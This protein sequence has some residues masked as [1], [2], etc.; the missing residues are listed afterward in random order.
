MNTENIV[1][2]NLVFQVESGSYS[3]GTNVEGSDRDMIGAF[4]PPPSNMIG[5]ST[6]EH[7]RDKETDENY[8]SMTDMVKHLRAGSSYWVEPLFVEPA[9]I[10][11]MSRHWSVLQVNREMFLTRALI[12]KTLGFIRGQVMRHEKQKT[13]S[14]SDDPAA[15]AAL[16]RKQIMH[17]VR[18]SYMI[19]DL[20]DE[21][22]FR[23]RRKE[24]PYL[25]DIRNGVVDIND[26]ANEANALH[27]GLSQQFDT[28]TL[29]FP[30]EANTD[31]L[32]E[33]TV[34]AVL[35]YWREKQ[36]I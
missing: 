29:P 9:N 16:N 5:L 32:N 36:W 24:A 2:Q 22:T 8:A 10:V 12:K 7:F 27:G 17:A 28:Q 21:G 11:I 6:I 3:Y 19:R 26:A 31:V 20:M 14:G 33:I 1:R 34:N 23:V 30:E 15:L 35:G 18:A 25:L 13:V 4:I